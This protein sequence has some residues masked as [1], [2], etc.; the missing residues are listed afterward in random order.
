MNHATAFFIFTS[1]GFALSSLRC[2]LRAIPLL[3]QITELLEKTNP[4]VKYIMD[5]QDP[6]ATKVANTIPLQYLYEYLTPDICFDKGINETMYQYGMAIGIP[7]RQ[8]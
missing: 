4:W 1:F 6:Y 5:S 2:K 8:F 7:Q 3:L